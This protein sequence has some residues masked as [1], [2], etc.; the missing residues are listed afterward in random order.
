MKP[1]QT[2]IAIFVWGLAGDAIANNAAAMANGFWAL[3]VR[4]LYMLYLH[5]APGP[6]VVLPEGAQ[7]ISLG[8]NRSRMAPLRLA[9]FL[10]TVRPDI[11]I[12]MPTI[13]NIPAIFGWLLSGKGSTKLIISENSTMSYKTYVEYKDDWRMRALP[14]MA[15]LIYPLA[16]GIRANS[17]EVLD[18]LLTKIRVSVPPNRSIAIT[19]PV[20]I[21]AVSNYGQGQPEHPWL[22]QKDKPVIISVARL[23]GQKNFPLLLLAFAEVRKSL[24]V[25][26]LIVGEGPERQ[27]LEDL[28]VQLEIHEHVSLPGFSNNPWSSMAKSDVF[29][30]P[31]EEEPFGLV[32]VE[33]M[34]CGT[35]IVATDALG[36]GPRHILENGKHGFL[37]PQND[38]AALSEAILKV[39]TSPDLHH[40]L[41]IAGKQRCQAFRPAIVAQDWFDFFDKL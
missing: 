13:V 15:R 39:L 12:S 36:G 31:S 3:G 19:N 21:E 22:Q 11:L 41:S 23:A 32:L 16:T 4:N 20:N 27:Q 17:P 10:R 7:V 40:H 2:T 37:V 33:A 14:W 6:N 5:A 9:Q 34:A 30:L 26:L 28:A 38:V 24:D 18:D 29:V 25:R 8:V 35:P 1:S